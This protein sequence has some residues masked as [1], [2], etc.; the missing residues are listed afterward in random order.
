V[1]GRDP[2][3][4]RVV[5]AHQLADALA[6][7]AGRLVGEGHREDLRS[8]GQPLAQEVRDAMGEHPRLPRSR[9]RQDEQ[10]AVAMADGLELRGVEHFRQRIHQPLSSM[11]NPPG[12]SIKKY[13]LKPLSNRVVAFCAVA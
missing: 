11:R 3:P 8:P 2:H 4:A 9:A 5:C 10:R 6:Q 12:R 1:K 7:L 13:R